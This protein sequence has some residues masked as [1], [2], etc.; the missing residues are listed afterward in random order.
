MKREYP[1]KKKDF[2][3]APNL[4]RDTK[5]YFI[6]GYLYKIQRRIEESLLNL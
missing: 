6:Y 3:R 4:K 5:E 2:S 1:Y